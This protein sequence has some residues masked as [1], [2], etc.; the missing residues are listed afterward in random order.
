MKLADGTF[1]CP[2]DGTLILSNEG[3]GSSDRTVMAFGLTGLEDE[4]TSVN[5]PK[6]GTPKPPAKPA[7]P[8][9]APNPRPAAA[10]L[11]E[12]ATIATREALD[13]KTAM[14]P[15]LKLPPAA[16][17]PLIGTRVG[18]Y[19]VESLIGEGG[20]GLVYRATQTDI[21]KAVAIKVLRDE[22]AENPDEVKRLL[23]EAKAVNAIRHRG[24]IDVFG[25]GKLK[26]GQQY[27]V[28]EFLEGSPLDEVIDQHAPMPVPEVI[29]I[30]DEVLSA[31]GAAHKA[32]VVHRDLKPNNIFHATQPDGTKYV[33]LLDF[34]LAKQGS[35]GG[36][37]VAQTRIHMAV[38][39]P[40]YIAPEQ[41]C[42]LPVSPKTDLYA[43]GVVAFEMLTGGRPF[44]SRN[45]LELLALHVEQAPPSMGSRGAE[46]P[47]ALE[48][49]VQRLLAKDAAKRP[50]SAEAVREALAGIRRDLGEQAT[51]VRPAR[52]AGVVPD[53]GLAERATAPSMAAGMTTAKV[54]HPGKGG[55]GGKVLLVLLVLALLG[56]G[57]A[58]LFLRYR[59]NLPPFDGA[60]FGEA[61]APA[62]PGK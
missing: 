41:A 1:A 59:A 2:R 26:N 16:R 45:P 15:S 27:I 23:A 49:L 22:V 57:G 42:G 38:G 47:D 6:G 51:R 40:E 46:L 5:Q 32:G 3:G 33:K 43:L 28:M 21:G 53:K 14:T 11:P 9:K 12:A 55:G 8:Q 58:W 44:N 48:G 24:I 4:R 52:A 13:V 25:F 17:D 20:V 61:V 54:K 19:L 30:L 29:A 35:T 60:A 18:D 31:L 34:G 7:R 37:A 56:A 10:R 62:A 36:G 50:E 39:T